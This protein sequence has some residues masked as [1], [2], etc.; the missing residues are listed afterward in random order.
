MKTTTEIV[1]PSY[2]AGVAAMVR[3]ERRFEPDAQQHRLY[4][5]RFERYYDRYDVPREDA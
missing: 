5:A 1:L 4:D 2:E 3:L